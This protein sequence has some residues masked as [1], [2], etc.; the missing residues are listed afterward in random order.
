MNK[1][2]LIFDKDEAFTSENSIVIIWNIDDVKQTIDDYDMGI[3]LTDDECMEVLSYV[4]GEHDA[5]LGVS[6]T[7]IQFA[8]EECFPKEVSNENI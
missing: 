5:T 3:E 7:T 6:W 4:E 2:V 1:E 8:I